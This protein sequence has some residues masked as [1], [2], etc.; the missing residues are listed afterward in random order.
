MKNYFLLLFLFLSLFQPNDL[1]SFQYDK[2]LNRKNLAIGIGSLLG[3]SFLYYLYNMTK[4][5]K[6]KPLNNTPPTFTYLGSSS[7]LTSI[8]LNEI[9]PYSQ[10][11]KNNEQSPKNET[12]LDLETSSMAPETSSRV[13]SK[14]NKELAEN[15]NQNKNIINQ[16]TTSNT[17]IKDY[18]KKRDNQNIKKFIQSVDTK[19]FIEGNSS[20]NSRQAIDVYLG[21]NEN[22]CKILFKENSIHGCIMYKN[23]Q[24]R[25]DPYTK[26][27]H[28]NFLAAKYDVSAEELLNDLE[29]S[30]KQMDHIV[31]N[32]W[33]INDDSIEWLT[34]NGFEKPSYSRTFQY[35]EKKIQQ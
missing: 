31:V 3:L 19:I 18:N 33:K 10:G 34:K 5:D 24:L 11:G 14:T 4:K 17:E 23:Q 9:A 8:D 35:L 28:I 32:D 2:Y 1:K 25:M 13:D 20:S 16:T 29:R 15:P 22:L 26:S 12:V 27:I 21:P 6:N 30:N 7:V